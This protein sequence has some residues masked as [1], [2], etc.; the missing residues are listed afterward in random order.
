MSTRHDDYDDHD[1][2]EHLE[3]FLATKLRNLRLTF[4]LKINISLVN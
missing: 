2:D 1:H 4:F 3:V